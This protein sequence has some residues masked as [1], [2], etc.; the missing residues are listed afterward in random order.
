DGFTTVYK[1]LD[2]VTVKAGDKVSKG[3][4]IGKVALVEDEMKDGAHIHLELYKDGKRINPLDYLLSG[5]K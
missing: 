5:D 1:L 2:N 3:D 4:V